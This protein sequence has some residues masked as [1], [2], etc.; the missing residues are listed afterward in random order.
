MK[1]KNVEGGE[2][3]PKR[4]NEFLHLTLVLYFKS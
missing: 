2:K 1:Q 4:V 3:N